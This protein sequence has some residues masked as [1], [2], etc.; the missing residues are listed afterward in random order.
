[1][2]DGAELV[3]DA[4]FGAGLSRALEG[5]AAETLAAAAQKR[6]PVVAIDA[7][8]AGMH[9]TVVISTDGSAARNAVGDPKS[10][11][12][13]MVVGLVDAEVEAAA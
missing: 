10:P 13:M 9:E 4:I 8:G 11:A 6:V 5:P 2:L 3:V 1:M 12:R 7:L